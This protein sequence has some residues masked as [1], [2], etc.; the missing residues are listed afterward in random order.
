MF[1]VD[2]L[3]IV[4]IIIYITT[5]FGY[6]CF[7]LKKEHLLTESIVLTSSFVF[8]FPLL[9][10]LANQSLSLFSIPP[11][12][13]VYANTI[14]D[15]KKY[16]NHYSFGVTGYSVL[17]F[18]QYK[19][20]FERPP[21]FVVY[22]IMYYQVGVLYIYKAFKIYCASFDKRIGLKFFLI[23]QLFS[24]FYPLGILQTTNI[25]REPMLLM[26]LSV[27]IYLLV[28]YYFKGLK[29][30]Y[31]IIL[32]ALLLF[33]IRPLTGICLFITYLLAYSHKNKF[34]TLKNILKFSLITVV[35]GFII[36]HIAL[37]LYSIDFSIDWIAQFREK[38]NS[39]FGIEGYK[40][41]N[42]E[43]PSYYFKN[44]VLLIL[45]YLLSPLPILVSPSVT[46]NKLIPL[47]D[48]LYIIA[49]ILPIMTF[50]K[51]YMKGWLLLF[52][53]FLIIPSIFETN[54]SGAYR[55]RMSAVIFLIPLATYIFMNIKIRKTYV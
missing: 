50:F 23:L 55:H 3:G 16:F 35:A 48:S 38:S 17:N 19:T 14:L 9:I 18:I 41:L 5:A 36:K 51:K 37:S 34:I 47:F 24:F 29:T 54:I 21:V 15:F 39:R 2:L 28:K 53:I 26:I 31:L 46:I 52:I 33:L 10:F 32:F 45:Q 44:I 4:L 13:E 1:K 27:N 20:C 30:Y 12:T 49:L 40:S 8:L 25:L 6:Y 42:W 7:L 43:N 22:N 11:D